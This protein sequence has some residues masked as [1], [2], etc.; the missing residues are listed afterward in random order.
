M[1]HHDP[2]TTHHDVVDR[3]TDSGFLVKDPVCGMDVDAHSAAGQVEH[4]G[5]TYYFCSTFCKAKFE[6]DPEQYVQPTQQSKPAAPAAA[7]AL[8]SVSVITNALRLRSK[9]LS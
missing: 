8:S 7:M 4:G 5:T 2:D 9:R 1:H 3:A 6:A